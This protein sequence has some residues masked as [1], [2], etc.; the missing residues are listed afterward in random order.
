METGAYELLQEPVLVTGF[1]L[2]IKGVS[3]AAWPPEAKDQDK[4]QIRVGFATREM[5]LSMRHSHPLREPNPGSSR[6][7]S[8]NTDVNRSGARAVYFSPNIKMALHLKHPPNNSFVLGG[9]PGTL[10]NLPALQLGASSHPLVTAEM[11]EKPQPS[12]M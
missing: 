6:A 12:F 10:S 9:L 8:N 5:V 3:P 1:L 7:S 4:Q 2:H 11:S